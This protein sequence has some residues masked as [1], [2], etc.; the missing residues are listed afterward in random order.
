MV[1][2]VDIL[3]INKIGHKNLKNKN[4]EENHKIN[5]LRVADFEYNFSHTEGIV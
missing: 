2:T 1:L 5:Y 4:V 3:L